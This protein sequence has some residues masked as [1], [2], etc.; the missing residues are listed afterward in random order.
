V[1][2]AEVGAAL[3]DQRIAGD[4]EPRL[5]AILK[6]ELA[7]DVADV[8]LHRGLADRERGRDLLVREPLGE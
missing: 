2:P 7:E 5:Q 4:V 8:L 1:T 6:A 3:H